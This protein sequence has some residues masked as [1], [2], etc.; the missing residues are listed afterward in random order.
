MNYLLLFL[1]ILRKKQCLKKQNKY[2][3][4]INYFPTIK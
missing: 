4:V 2:K 3:I 1:N